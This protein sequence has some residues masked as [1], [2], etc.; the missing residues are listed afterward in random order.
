[1]ELCNYLIKT[2][3]IRT[4]EVRKPEQYPSEEELQ[5]CGCFS[6][7]LIKPES[8]SLHKHCAGQVVLR[9]KKIWDHT[10]RFIPATLQV[11]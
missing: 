1:M 11:L 7:L 2:I 9:R 4:L 6:L 5:K 8:K 10:N 3:V